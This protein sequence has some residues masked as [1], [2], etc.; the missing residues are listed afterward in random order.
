MKE[1]EYLPKIQ[2]NHFPRLSLPVVK[3]INAYKSIPALLSDHVPE[4][5]RASAITNGHIIIKCVFPLLSRVTTL[6]F[7][8][9]IAY[10]NL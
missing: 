1:I 9:I 3:S 6:Y 5:D 8:M 2:V 4:T 10:T 7:T